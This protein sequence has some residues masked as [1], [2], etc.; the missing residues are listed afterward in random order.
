MRYGFLALIVAFCTMI[1]ACKLKPTPCNP[2][3]AGE[4]LE[5]RI[6]DTGGRDILVATHD[7]PQIYQ[8]CRVLPLTRQFKSYRIPGGTDTGTIISFGNIRTPEYGE[9]GECFRIYINWI[10]DDQDTVDWHFKIEEVDGCN[11]QII[12]YMSYNGKQAERKNDYAHEYY[13]FLKR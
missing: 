4:G 3:P 5:F 6:V 13:Q 12:D 2:L 8:P 7:T 9:P 11:L 10:N 1:A